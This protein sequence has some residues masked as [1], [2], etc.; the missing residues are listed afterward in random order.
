MGYITKEVYD[1]IDALAPFKSCMEWD[2]V[3]LLVGSADET[4]NG[5]LVTLDVTPE[6][7][8]EAKRLGANCIVSH[9]PVIFE[10]LKCVGADSVPG[11]CLAAGI[12]II[13]A[14][15]NYDFAPQGVNYA[16]AAV[17]G[18]RNIRPF[19]TEEPCGMLGELS[20]PMTAAGLAAYWEEALGTHIQYVPCKGKI[21]T[22][23]VCG[24][25]GS[26]F[27]PQAVSA[28]AGAF[29]TGEVKHHEWFAAAK[30]GICLMA[31]GHHATE[32]PAVPQLAQQLRDALP[33]LGIAVFD[34]NPTRW[35]KDTK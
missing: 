19:G 22:V 24:G 17:L 27:L 20:Q 13:S 16:L 29:L 14:H 4:V 34:S 10:A 5:V 32:Q 28:G 25:A 9:H 33:G 6:A 15:T 23:A 3:G 21:D 31:G 35:G 1:A 2:N 11:L 8:A 7:V 30:S 18:L 26:D 12:S